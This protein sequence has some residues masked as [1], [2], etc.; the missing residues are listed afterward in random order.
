M[1]DPTYE[2]NID[3]SFLPYS[4]MLQ[5]KPFLTLFSSESTSTG[6]ASTGCLAPK[7]LLAL[8]AMGSAYPTAYNASEEQKTNWT[9]STC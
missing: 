9:Q 1:S 4:T 8:R 5:S 3:I 7:V 6:R 2:V